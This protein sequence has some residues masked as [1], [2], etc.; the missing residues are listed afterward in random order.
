M[1]DEILI[2]SAQDAESQTRHAVALR[3]ALHHHHV[4][5]GFE[6][7]VA[8]QRIGGIVDAEID[9]GF[10]DHQTNL[11]FFAPLGQTQHVGL[12]YEVT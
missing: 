4:G 5:I 12:G 9:E 10:I 2:G 3:D 6:N 8:E 1:C 11:A 7:I